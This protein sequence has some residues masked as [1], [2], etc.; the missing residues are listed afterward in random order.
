MEREKI[1]LLIKRYEDVYLFATKRISS[2]I[3]ENVLDDL[4][5]EQ[6]SMLRKVHFEGPIRASE[7]TEI[8]NVNKSAIAVK[9]DKLESKGLISRERDQNDRRNVYI[10]ATEQGKQVCEE[11]EFKIEKFVSHYLK[12]LDPEDLEQFINLY[13]KITY[14]IQNSKEESTE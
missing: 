6:F 9:V 10:T 11:V 4:S 14:I 8:L 3:S 7:L 2:L 1:K 13:E 5:L 12:E